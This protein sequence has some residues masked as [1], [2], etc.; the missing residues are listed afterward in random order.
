MIFGEKLLLWFC[1][2]PIPAGWAVYAPPGMLQ[3]P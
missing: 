1:F 3:L 2:F